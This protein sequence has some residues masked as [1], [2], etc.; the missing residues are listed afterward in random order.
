MIANILGENNDDN[1]LARSDKISNT[2]SN[3]LENIIGKHDFE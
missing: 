1:M 2:V 3:H